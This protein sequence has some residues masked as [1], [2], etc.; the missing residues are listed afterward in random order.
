MVANISI[1]HEATCIPKIRSYINAM[2]DIVLICVMQ[3]RAKSKCQAELDRALASSS[4][5]CA[6]PNVAATIS[7][8]TS[9]AS[10]YTF[11]DDQQRL[12]TICM[13]FT[14]TLSA[15][16]RILPQETASSGRAPESEPSNC[17]THV[18]SIHDWSATGM[19]SCP[20]LMYTA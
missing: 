18:R 19:T 7:G 8:K 9:V 20:V 14:F 15:P 3:D 10:A 4:A 5:Q 1:M 17:Q 6:F 16:A 11:Y 2:T 12:T 13:P